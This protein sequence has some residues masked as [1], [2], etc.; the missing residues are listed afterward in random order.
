MDT[1]D[2][3]ATLLVD[4]FSLETTI[5][6]AKLFQKAGADGLFVASAADPAIIKEIALVTT[7][8]LNVLGTP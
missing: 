3:T 8:P 5:K 4:Q 2:F 6:R 1:S 7:L